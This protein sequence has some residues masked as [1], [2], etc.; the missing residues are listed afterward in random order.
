MAGIMPERRKTLLNQSI[1]HHSAQT[2]L[3]FFVQKSPLKSIVYEL[4]LIS[5]QCV[6]HPFKWF[7]FDTVIILC[8]IN[9]NSIFWCPPEILPIRHKFHNNKYINPYSSCQKRVLPV[10]SHS[11]LITNNNNNL[12]YLQI[13]QL[14]LFPNFL[15]TI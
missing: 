6:Y 3:Y 15:M 9:T 8:I 12:L 11:Y 5:Y 7:K 4:K 2:P 10:S 1:N 13:P 14:F